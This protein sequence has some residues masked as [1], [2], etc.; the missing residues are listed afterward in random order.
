V[1]LAH[2]SGLEDAGYEQGYRAHL[3]KWVDG[4]AV[5]QEIFIPSPDH[6]DL[7]QWHTLGMNF[8]PTTLS[9]YLDGQLI[10]T[11]SDLTATPITVGSL[12]LVFAQQ[13]QHVDNI[14]ITS[15][16]YPAPAPVPVPAPGAFILAAVG[17]SC[18][19]R[20]LRR[21]EKL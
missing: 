5:I 12:E 19:G 7:G 16:P 20:V 21:C 17:L 18:V 1:A 6:Y 14:F 2:D 4:T 10:M 11:V 13:D 15:D 3:E 9:G 8:S